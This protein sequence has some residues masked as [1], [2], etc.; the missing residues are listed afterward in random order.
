MTQQYELT[1]YESD[2]A[3]VIWYSYKGTLAECRAEMDNIDPHC[4][5]TLEP[6]KDKIEQLRQAIIKEMISSADPDTY[7]VEAL[8]QMTP[9]Q[10]VAL[11][12]SLEEA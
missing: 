3:D 7:D 11:Q 4:T 5:V 12:K 6:I 1:V 8:E 10:L 9:E 2:C